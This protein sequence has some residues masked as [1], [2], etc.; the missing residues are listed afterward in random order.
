MTDTEWGGREE[1]WIHSKA[2]RSPQ[3]MGGSG[4]ACTSSLLRT[5]EEPGDILAE[6]RKESGCRLPDSMLGMTDVNLSFDQLYNSILKTPVSKQKLNSN[7]NR[8]YL[9]NE[10]LNR[11]RDCLIHLKSNFKSCKKSTY[12]ECY[13]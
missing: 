6:D 8:F 3:G 10:L 11:M 12:K 4:K 5:V 1:S 7:W 2:W 13:Y 9:H